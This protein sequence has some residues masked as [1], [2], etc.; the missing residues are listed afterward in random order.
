MEGANLSVEVPETAQRAIRGAQCAG[1]L[2]LRSRRAFLLLFITGSGI[3]N[4]I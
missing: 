3:A 4:R 1:A 2:L